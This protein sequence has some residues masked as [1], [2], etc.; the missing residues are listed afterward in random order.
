ML[1]I[2]EEARYQKAINQL[3]YCKQLRSKRFEQEEEN[4][5]IIE[6]RKRKPFIYKKEYTFRPFFLNHLRKSIDVLDL[7]DDLFEKEM[8]I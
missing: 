2:E 8:I 6:S 4:K 5:K 7:T 3:N 1:N